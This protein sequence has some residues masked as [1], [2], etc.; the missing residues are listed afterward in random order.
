MVRY[1]AL[2]EGYVQ[3]VGFRYYVLHTARLLELTGW[4]RNREDGLVELEA[5]GPPDRVDELLAAVRRG[6]S[7]S[8]VT[9]VTVEKREPDRWERS[10]EVGC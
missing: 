3:G 7:Y 2:V 6:S 4:V 10:F 5:Q 9:H 1:H 8:T